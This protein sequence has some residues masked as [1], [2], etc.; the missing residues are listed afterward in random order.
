[1]TKSAIALLLAIGLS[2]RA[3]SGQPSSHANFRI[4][5]FEVQPASLSSEQTCTL[6]FG[7]HHFYHEKTVRKR[8]RDYDRKIYEGDLSE[9]EWNAL[10]GIIDSKEFR[11]LNVPRD[12]EPLV[13]QDA[14]P[15][16][17]SV[18]RENKYQNLEFLDNKSL[19]PYYSQVSPLLKWWKSLRSRHLTESNA[20]ADERCS[21]DMGRPLISH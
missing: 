15:Y 8:G 2:A 1:V 6:V 13:V 20:P 3:A 12:V 10:S 11:E 9:S 4:R 16:T 14:H 19:K 5:L 17:I 7:D 18:A 21:P